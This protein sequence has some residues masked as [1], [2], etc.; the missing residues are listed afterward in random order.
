MTPDLGPRVRIGVVTTDLPLHLSNVKRDPSMMKFCRICKKCAETCPA[1]AISHND[2]E[3]SG[4]TTQW[5][6]NQEACFTYWCRSGTDCGRCIS[7]CPYSHPDNL[8]HRLVRGLIRTS[9]IFLHFAAKMDNWLYGKKPQ[10]KEL[11]AWMD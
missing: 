6:I 7:V 3:E 5:V 8:L 2:P 4:G 1:Q 10:E 11:P 9:P